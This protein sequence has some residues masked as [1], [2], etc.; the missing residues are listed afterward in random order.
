MTSYAYCYDLLESSGGTLTT[1]LVGTAKDFGVVVPG[2][3]TGQL[4]TTLLGS[5]GYAQERVTTDWLKMR[6]DLLTV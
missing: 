2:V 4:P 6:V 1:V 5:H 3:R